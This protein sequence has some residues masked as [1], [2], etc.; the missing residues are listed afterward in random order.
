M[1]AL[2]TLGKFNYQHIYHTEMWSG[3]GDVIKFPTIIITNIKEEEK[4]ITIEVR[5]IKEWSN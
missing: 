4:E 5:G 1:I 2:A 3:G